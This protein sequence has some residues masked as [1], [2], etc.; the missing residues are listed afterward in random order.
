M[1]EYGG[2]KRIC[3]KLKD[4]CKKY[5]YMVFLLLITALVAAYSPLNPL[6][7]RGI[8][9]DQAVFLT[10]A[11]GM[12]H[13]KLAYVDFFDHKGILL[14]LI[15]EL[16]LFLSDG[17][18]G[19]FVI[20]IGFIF[21]SVFFLYKIARLFACEWISVVAVA[22]IFCSD[23]T[24]YTTS[25]SEEYLFPILCCSVYLFLLQI[26]K[27]SVTY[28]QVA[29]IGIGASLVFFIKFNYCL[30]WAFIGVMLFVHMLFQREGLNRIIR[31]CLSFF[32]GLA[33]GAAPFIIYHLV[34]GSFRAFLDTYVLYSFHYADATGIR[35]RMNCIRFLLDTPIAVC[36]Y[37]AILAVLICVIYL[38][39][40]KKKDVLHIDERRMRGIVIFLVLSV[41]ILVTTASPGQ[42]W[43]Y[44]KQA[45]MVIYVVP[46]A[47]LLYM[48]DTLLREKIKLPQAVSI[49]LLGGVVLFIL[50]TR[51]T[52]EQYAITPD[53][54]F[55]GAMAICDL[56]EENCD[57]K[58][59]MISFSN[60][61]TMYFY[62]GCQPASRLFFPSAAV[63]GD[64]LTD[65]L[66]D[67]LRRNRPKIMTFQVDWTA[68][69][70]DY[71]ISEAEAFTEANYA[72]LY[73]DAYRR[74]YLRRDALA[75]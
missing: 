2:N 25:N 31:M 33:A 1:G 50:R 59:T 43:Y 14:Y 41:V 24:L 55:A 44:Y 13:G 68:G 17:L 73:E 8:T 29:L 39:A 57:E 72:L 27:G 30:I 47:V 53:A 22:A 19:N 11:R 46:I 42:S 3:M 4:I 58:D 62:S 26:V 49:I 7:Q 6:T 20:E 37:V 70:S 21:L 65:A 75:Q 60:D 74:A 45:T 15:L 9:T 36:Y 16:G 10:I 34:T 28:W 56:I 52:P 5:C 38:I 12:Q 35:E 32:G 40:T 48:A 64:D 54:R 69:M 67:D 66:M 18:M 23:I 71:F 51:L 61:C 63:L